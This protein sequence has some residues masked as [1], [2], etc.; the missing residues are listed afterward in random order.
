MFGIK[1]N[2]K[3]FFNPVYFI[4]YGIGLLSKLYSCRPG[5]HT[6]T[7]M[8]YNTLGFGHVFIGT[9]KEKRYTK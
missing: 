2:K 6:S 4:N 9:V 5:L 3:S 1:T 7:T 8:T